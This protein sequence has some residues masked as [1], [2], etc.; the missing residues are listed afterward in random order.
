M[1]RDYICRLRL[2]IDRLPAFFRES[3]FFFLIAKKIFKLPDELFYFREDYNKG[4]IKDLALYYDPN[5]ELN[6]ERSSEDIDINSFHIEII[7]EFVDNIKPKS[8]LDVGC[9]TGFLLKLLD[10]RLN[11]C[12]LQ[13]IDFNSPKSFKTNKK[14][15]ISFISG[16]INNNLKSLKANSFDLV[17]CAHVLEHLSNPNEL[18]TEMRRISKKMLILI[19]PL[20]KPYKWGMNYHVQFF[21]YSRNFIDLVRKDKNSSRNFRYFEKLGDCMYV[22]TIRKRKLKNYKN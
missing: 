21:E 12:E 18:I 20:E 9:G 6:L 1:K 2:I 15:K 4:K 8:I 14:N 7:N 11:M 10:K 19:C 16:D 5:S 3:K 17:I 22:E 13:G